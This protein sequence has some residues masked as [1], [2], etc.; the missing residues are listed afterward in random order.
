[1]REDLRRFFLPQ[2][3]APPAAEEAK[4]EKVC[5][6][7]GAGNPTSFEKADGQTRARRWR[8][9]CC[10]MYSS[11]CI[12]S[13]DNRITGPRCLLV[14]AVCGA[15]SR[16]EKGWPPGP[17]GRPSSALAFTKCKPFGWRVLLFIFRGPAA[18]GAAVR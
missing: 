18:A 2:L 1:M 8:A 7:S 11:I 15:L 13:Q 10:C 6:R 14:H 12:V 17:T 5:L 4:E 9:A 16:D 3:Y